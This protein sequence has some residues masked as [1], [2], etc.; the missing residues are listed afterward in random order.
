MWIV[1]TIGTE[2]NRGKI[3][4]NDENGM[5][6]WHRPFGG[7]ETYND[8]EWLIEVIESMSGEKV[9]LTKEI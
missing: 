8:Y 1:K 7:V 3:F 2:F 6:V 4:F 5:W 9:Y